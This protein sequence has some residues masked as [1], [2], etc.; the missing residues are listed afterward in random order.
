M[1]TPEDCKVLKVR[2]Y[3]YLNL[4]AWGSNRLLYCLEMM[5]VNF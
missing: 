4:A 2:D 3:V 1:L 5:V